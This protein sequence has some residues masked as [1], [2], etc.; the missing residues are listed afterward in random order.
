LSVCYK[1]FAGHN[2]FSL[3][4]HLVLSTEL[5]VVSFYCD[6]WLSS[7]SFDLISCCAYVSIHHPSFSHDTV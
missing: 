1:E 4:S 2:T 3:F 7:I 5:T 6:I